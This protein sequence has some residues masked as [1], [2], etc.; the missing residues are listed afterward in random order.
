[1]M[2]CSTVLLLILTALVANAQP[3][4]PFV[5]GLFTD[6]MIL[7]RDV[8]CPIWGWTTPGATVTV[9]LGEQIVTATAGADGRWQASIGPRPAG[10]PHTITVAGPQTITLKNVLFG[11]IW[12]CSGQ[13]NMDF[14]IDGVNQWWN[15][16][17]GGS[18]DGIRL[19]WVK[20]T[21]SFA[22]EATVTGTWSVASNESLLRKKQP[23]TT[24]GF[25]AIAWLFGRKIHQQTG[26]PIGMI[27]CAQGNTSI[28]PWSTLASLRQDPAYGA[29]LE[30][31]V[32]YEQQVTDWAKKSDPAFVQTDGWR[33]P[34]FDDSAWPE[35]TLPG[36][37][38]K[39]ALPGFSGLVWFRRTV[40]LPDAWAGCDLWLN[41]GPIENQEVT[42]VNGVFVGGE[43]GY[44]RDHTFRVPG[45]LIKAGPNVITVR[46]LGSRGFAG[47][48]DQLTLSKGNGPGDSLSL[49]GA[50]KIQASTPAGKLT[51]RSRQY[52]RIWTP[53]G[54]YHGMVAPLA[55]F[56]IKGVLWYQ[57]E[58]NAGQSAYERQLTAMIR[59][60]RATFGQG[61]FPFYIVQLAGFGPMPALPGGSSW[62]LT[63]ELQARVARTVPNCGL[64]VAIDRG[65]I[66]DIHP[67][68]KRDVSER[69]AAVAL[70]KSYGKDLP[71]EG[72]TY[73]G[74]LMDGGRIRL[75]FTHAAGLK[76]I[77]SGP[78]GFAIAGADRR[79]YWA[80]SWLDGETVVVSAPEVTAPVAVR[81]GWSDNAL[82][83]LYNK[84][85][86]PAVP[87]RTDNW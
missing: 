79:F 5:H 74:L 61:D 80:Q 81:Y 16:L 83:N 69:L 37:W 28:Q 51:G 49:A 26:I 55:P 6:H 34:A 23:F 29:T 18:V 25:S 62:A 10:G 54:L 11:D 43:D 45:K 76:S 72:P 58:G 71:C 85:N 32:Y 35:I 19:Y 84:D 15:E 53:G 8:A 78:T 30:P 39:S 77:G 87:F 36:E 4:P 56:A 82:C 59:D 70:A 33:A 27:E 46:V 17:P 31:Q 3:A 60:W 20:P 64:A 41:L 52:D 14:G 7:Q 68:N 50:W 9:T 48:P 40:I 44:R 57:G 63:R 42:W 24:V 75:T 12:I 13:S 38:G 65:E 47:K 22:P 86:L 21:S 1:M 73:Q 67:P 2:R 66:Y